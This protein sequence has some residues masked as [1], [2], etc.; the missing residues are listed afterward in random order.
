VPGFSIRLEL[1]CKMLAK[2]G[3]SLFEGL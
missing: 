1:F 2:L 3:K